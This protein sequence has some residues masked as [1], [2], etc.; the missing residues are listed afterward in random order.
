MRIRALSDCLGAEV[1][2]VDVRN[3]DERG[4]TRI[5]DAWLTHN[6]VL[7]VHLPKSESAKPKRI[8]VKSV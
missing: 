6:G 1:T 8:A 3:L 4:F 5:Y 7:V 2:D